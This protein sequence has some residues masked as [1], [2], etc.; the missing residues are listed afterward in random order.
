MKIEREIFYLI[1]NIDGFEE[2]ITSGSKK[3]LEKIKARLEYES[4]LNNESKV[5]SNM[6]YYI[7][8]KNEWDFQN[9]PLLPVDF[10]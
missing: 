8:P 6:I 2:I 9:C 3:E 1:K 7:I 10:P 4:N 5:L